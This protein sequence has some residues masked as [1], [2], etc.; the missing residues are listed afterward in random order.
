MMTAQDRKNRRKGRRAL[1]NILAS[2][3]VKEYLSCF[4]IEPSF[5][6]TTTRELAA[7]CKAGHRI[8]KITQDAQDHLDL[9]YLRAKIQRDK[10]LGIPKISYSIEWSNGYK[11]ELSSLKEIA[12]IYE[13]VAQISPYA[14]VV[15]ITD[16]RGKKYRCELSA[17][18]VQV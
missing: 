17:R 18:I 5:H 15:A 11:E 6:G 9:R 4:W 12:H 8:Q 13:I 10:V 7:L 3:A 1:A 16:N 14:R 2:T